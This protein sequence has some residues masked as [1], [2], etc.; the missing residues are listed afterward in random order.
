MNI[1]TI[2]NQEFT[3]EDI[4]QLLHMSRELLEANELVNAQLIA[5]MAKLS[6]EESKVKKLQQQ[7]FFYSQAFTNNT[8]NA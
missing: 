8:Y 3:E 5:C 2:N 1:I 4:K 7:L 6:N